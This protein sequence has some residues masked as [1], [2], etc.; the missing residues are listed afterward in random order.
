MKKVIFF[1]IVINYSL[2]FAQN[3]TGLMAWWPLNGNFN[4]SSGNAFHGQPIGSP[5]STSDRFNNVGGAI[6][7][8]G[9]TNMGRMGDILD[10][11]FCKNPAAKF[12]IS[13]WA[14]STTINSAFGAGLIIAKQAGGSGPDQWSVS[15]FNDST[16]RGI[17]K[18]SSLWDYVEWKSVTKVLPDQWFFYVLMF[19]GS[20]SNEDNRVMFYVNG[21]PGVFSRKNGTFGSYCSNT[22]QEITIGSGHV[23]GSPA[24]PNNQ[25]FG[26]IDDVRIY[27]RVLSSEEISQLYHQ[28]N[29]GLK[30]TFKNEGF[31]VTCENTSES[32]HFNFVLSEKLKIMVF[33]NHGRLVWEKIGEGETSL[34]VSKKGIYFV[35]LSSDK[36]GSK[37]VKLLYY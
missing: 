35:V 37:V 5:N 26:S 23:A 21:I 7:F 9:S 18:T 16:V 3:T 33:D 6:L 31:S 27:N 36:G 29:T 15:H 25:F 28:P 8:N 30:G 11:V 4:D 14:K 24:S 22:S 10:S 17:V 1:L 12:S 32:G 20:I 34:T 2:G 19:D 13:G